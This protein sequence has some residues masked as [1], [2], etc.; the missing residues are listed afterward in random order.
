MA[1]MDRF[2]Y[3]VSNTLIGVLNLIT[4]VA[5]I[6]IIGAGLWM[7]RSSTTCEK[8]LQ[9][10]LLAIGF[11]I[12]TV[13]LAGFIGA[14]FRL[15]WVLWLYLLV[16][17]FL[18]AALMGVTIFGF[19]VTSRGGGVAVP[20]KVYK[21]YRLPNYSGWLR[22]KVSDP[23]NWMPIRG[24]ILG[25]NTCA[26][27]LNWTPSDYQTNDMSP[28]RSGCCKPPTSCNYGAALETQ[29]SDCKRWNND[30][31]FLC[32]DCDS[33]K[34][35]VLED[36]RREWQKISMLNIIMVVVLIV[37][38]SVGCCAFENAKIADSVQRYN[39]PNHPIY[40][41][42]RSRWPDLYGKFPMFSGGARLPAW[43]KM[44]DWI[45]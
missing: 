10:P 24:C 2:Y 44:R 43:R 18:I 19:V 45:F 34:A 11:I 41:K 3:G 28:L 39:A 37:V 32:Y 1:G 33:C 23:R 36:M 15:T 12:L 7:A 8:F 21:E 22:M 27:I 35:A 14:C 16:M 29:D 30:P 40:I 9:T 6:P 31:S 38:Y 13:S 17:L 5:S 25:S 4:L 42:P 20:G 26:S